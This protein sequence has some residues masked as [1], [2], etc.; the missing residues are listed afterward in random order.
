MTG[1]SKKL[2]RRG[3]LQHSGAAGLAA[4]SAGLLLPQAGFANS[5]R[6]GGHFVLGLKGGESTDTLDPALSLGSANSYALYAFGDYLVDITP[7]GGLTP[8]LA[9]SWEAA[10]GGK[11]WHFRIRKSVEFHNGKSLTAE[12]VLKTMQRH[13]N[14]DSQSGA[15]GIMRGVESMKADGDLF[16]V[17]LTTPNADLP[18]LM[19][20]Y[21]LVIQ[22]NGGMDSPADGVG[23][24]PYRLTEEEPGVRYSFAKFANHWNGQVG[25][26][27]THEIIAINDD[28]A[29]VAALQ[30]GQVH[31][32]DKVPPRIANLVGRA[33]G[34]A[35]GITPGR[36]H[37]IFVMHTDTPPFDNKD[38]RLALKYAINRQELVDTVLNGYG[39][40]GNDIPISDAYPLFDETLPQRAFSLE[41]AAEHYGLSG[42]DGSPIILQVSDAAFPG[43]IDAAQLFQ[44]S[45]KAAGIP[46]EIKR[47]PADGYWSEVWNKQPFC[48]SFWGG[49]PVQDQMWSTGYLSSAD[50]N[51]TRFNNPEFDALLLEAR[52]ELDQ[53]R[54]RALYARMARIVWEEGGLINPMFNQFIDGYSEKLGGWTQHYSQMMNGFAAKLT[55]FA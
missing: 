21:H 16:T 8:A 5:P 37:Y 24:G 48:A 46:L 25:H 12:D 44:Q 22:P 49:R 39:S 47:E 54:R 14:E 52:A 45:A 43:A 3:F 28:T 51:D 30:S 20:D 15:L 2:S 4:T 13:S 35:V 55:W 9:E 7:D 18:Y 32:I 23:S 38:L 53:T 26:Y 34:V 41:K 6:K 50:W 36:G 1:P 17:T 10:E 29:R 11:V 27:D 40:V 19:T 42:H 31:A 33:P